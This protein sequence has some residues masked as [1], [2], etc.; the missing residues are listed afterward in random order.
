MVLHACCG[1][2]VV[3]VSEYDL[4]HSEKE[5]GS[6][7]GGIALAAYNPDL[8]LFKRQLQSIQQQTYTNW[9]CAISVDG[10]VAPVAEFVSEITDGDDRFSVS[11]SGRRLGFYANF[12]RA[13]TLLPQRL[14]WYAFSDQD[15]FWYPTKISSLVPLLDDNMAVS[16]QARVVEHPSR[17][18]V[19][20]A[21]RR[22]YH[23]G[24]AEIL[25]NQFS[26]AMM[27]FRPEILELALPF[28][29]YRSPSEVHDHWVA[30]CAMALGS[31]KIIDTVLQDYVQ[32]GANVIG[33]LTN[34]SFNLL[35][36][37]RSL[38]RLSAKYS[39]G[40]SLGKLSSTVTKTSIGWRHVMISQ[41]M[42]R[43]QRGDIH[44]QH[45]FVHSVTGMM[46]SKLLTQALW[47]VNA[48]MEGA[49]LASTAEYYASLFSSR[50]D[51]YFE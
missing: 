35:R 14:D 13:L 9:I 41:I 2:Q 43:A 26:G 28:P 11:G 48:Y 40:T 20:E 39:D 42:S 19:A 45:N 23:G 10:D 5:S 12:E 37:L 38:F 25:D 49:S 30:V 29:R 16:G 4:H 24:R 7:T 8:V 44:L 31:V 17:R 50:Y 33:E 36:S 46:N 47:G 21:T 22:Q 18:I 34:P 15:D 3:E 6:M 32:H 1:S 51:R 27:M